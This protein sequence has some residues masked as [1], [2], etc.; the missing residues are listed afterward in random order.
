MQAG[1]GFPLMALFV[2]ML[3]H[4]ALAGNAAKVALVFIYTLVALAMFAA[5]GEV[6]WRE[7]A[8]L[9]VGMIVGGVLGAKLQLRVGPG[10]VR[11][12]MLVMVAI[13]GVALL[14]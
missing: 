2:S 1:V 14:L 7:G 13:S 10:L 8:I 6:A 12:A 4:T 3:G 9:A 11:W 5:S